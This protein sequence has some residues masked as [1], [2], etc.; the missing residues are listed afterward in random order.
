MKEVEVWETITDVPKAKQGGVLASKLPNDSKLKKDLRDKF[1]ESVD[2]A[3]LATD[4]GLKLVKT[5]LEEELGEDDLEKQ[6][7]TWDEFED[8]I[9][10]TSG[11]EDFL[12]T[13]DRAYKKAAAASKATIPAPVRAFMVLKRSNIDKTQRMLVLSKLDKND[14]KNMFENMCKEL[15]LVLGGGPGTTKQGHSSAAIK[16]DQDSLPSDEVLFAA[17]YYKRGGS[18]SGRS[19]GK[20]SSSRGG[21]REERKPYEKSEKQVKKTNRLDDEGKPTTCH[22]CG[23]KYHYKNKCPDFE[24]INAVTEEEPLILFTDD[25]SELSQFTQEALNCAAL[26]T[27]CSSSVVGEEWLEIYIQSLDSR[28]RE[29]VEGPIKSSKVFK[30]GNNGKLSSQGKYLLPANLAGKA[31]KLSVD[32][33]KSDIPL[34]LSKA[35][36][37]KAGM[38][39]DLKEDTVTVFGNKEKLVT[40]SCGHYCM[41]LL[42]DTAKAIEETIEEVLSIDLLNINEKEKVA[43]MEKLHKQFGHTNKE[44][45]VA[46]MKDANVWHKGLEKILDG[47]IDKC[48]GCIKKKR[49]P[50]KP[51]VGLPMA[52]EFNEK[53]AIDLKKWNDKHILHMVDM[54]SRFT[55]SCFINRKRP[56]DVI[57]KIMEKWI[58]YFGVMKCIL[59]DNGGEFTGEEIREVKDILNVV[60]LTTGAE[61]PWM[62]GLCEK[63][64]ALV[65]D[66]LERMVED[67]PETPDHVLLGWANMAKNSMQ[68]VY[69]YSSNQLVFGTNPSLPNIMTNGLP[70]L[71]GKTHSEI[72]AQHIN[73]LQAARKAFTESENSDRVRKAL[74]RKVCTNNTVYEHGDCVW[75]KREKDDKWKGP[76]KVIFQDGKV[77]WVRH[78]SAA[79]RV[80]VNRLIKQGMELAR[81]DE[82]T[83]G[84][85][86]TQDD[87]TSVSKTGTVN[88]TS[89]YSTGAADGTSVSSN[90]ILRNTSVYPKTNGTSGGDDLVLGSSDEDDSVP[91]PITNNDSTPEHTA[92]NDFAP[93][94]VIEDAFVPNH[95]D[96]E[97]YPGELED[98]IAHSMETTVPVIE[99]GGSKRKADNT[100][101]GS[102]KRSRLEAPDDKWKRFPN[103]EEK[104][105]LNKNDMIKINLNEEEWIN[106]AVI[107]RG[108][109]SGK[110]Y[111]HF[112][113]LGEDG[114]ERN[115]DLERI[116]YEKVATDEVNIV[117]IPREEQCSEECKQ[118][119]EVEL[120]KL[121]GFDSFELVE[122]EGQYRISCRW[123]L[124]K[125]GEETRARLV[126]RGFE[127]TDEVP[128]DS[129]TVDKSNIR[130]LLTIA[131]SYGWTIKCSDV[132]SAFL[133]GKQLERLV[134]MVPPKEANVEKGKLWK[135]KVALYGLDDASLQFFFKCKEELIKLGCQ[136]S[137]RDPA[138]F[139]KK[140]EQGKLMGLIAL[141]V[142]DF[143]HAGNQI[144]EK[145]VTE[146]LSKI[147]EMGKI[148]EKKFS[149]VGFDI[150]QKADCTIIDQTRYVKEKIN[151]IRCD[152][153]RAKLPDEPLTSEERSQMRIYAGKVGWLARGSRPDLIF[154][155]IEMS[156]KFV[157]GQV[158]D[159]IEA[160]KAMRKA[161]TGESFV[162]INNLGSS[163]KWV[164]EVWTDASLYTLNKGL[165]STR[166][167]LILLVN[168][169]GICVP[170][171]WQAN[172]IKRIVRSTL[173]AEC[174]ALVEG[175]SEGIYIREIIEEIMGLQERTI[176]IKAIIDNKSTV[177][178]V[179]STSAVSDKR[180]RRDIGIIKQMM[181]EGEV[182]SLTWCAGK[183]QLADAMTKRT[184]SP[185][186]ILSVFQLGRRKEF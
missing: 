167:V 153:S 11:I 7:R 9:R 165:N 6:V 107:N 120:S 115:V 78:G 44:K 158:R 112:N 103:Q 114:L 110:Y 69:G 34:L 147:F 4:D 21:R 66:M 63:N 175:L 151:D 73:A 123:V 59:N 1:F 77:V 155:Q 45:F 5:F 142:D 117:M 116:P 168:E 145:N 144:F 99:E 159:L 105:C 126:A 139:F 143:L 124:W 17:G 80:S 91:E 57:D 109:V 177:E 41:P 92:Q 46:F 29:K 61:S 60:D 154:A 65:D 183:D 53:V 104:I 20:Y 67:Y 140:N 108:K 170:I 106:A 87:V 8:C 182:K 70:A 15:K 55:I 33:I 174:L 26:D 24:E 97:D 148:E 93:G 156:T 74:L 25:K 164:I 68:M 79:V 50:A 173:E 30:F 180:L 119:K 98:N 181:N 137:S 76:A 83:E 111:N 96:R 157:S 10:G 122:D 118:A 100:L 178:S 18:R 136:Q 58:A 42:A 179:H 23:S 2:I 54:Y 75:Y 43:A 86:Q 141:H 22:H 84:N 39:I 169:K 64:H 90:N 82:S 32:V 102:D 133:Q 27:C 13:F 150:D 152:P 19:F 16:V 3:E 89:V 172:K 101:S 14:N 132:K 184:A 128:S 160:M 48:V 131:Q 127:E 130:L 71:E 62:N 171:M 146:K 47:I 56:K 36:M 35:A 52:Q 125:K 51:V 72:F 185:Y 95:T 12:S 85:R 161:K 129:P 49:N 38:K 121:Q 176:P 163:E 162:T 113:I 166:A 81:Q 40:T 88:R 94:P 31:I 186:N 135:L 28:E 37:K 149:Y 134:T 138:L